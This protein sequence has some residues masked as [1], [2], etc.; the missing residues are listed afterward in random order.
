[1]AIAEASEASEASGNAEAVSGSRR[2]GTALAE[3]LARP[4]ATET[5]HDRYGAVAGVP[6]AA[7]GRAGSGRGRLPGA[8]GP[9]RGRAPAGGIVAL[10]AQL[11]AQMSIRALF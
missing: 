4:T 10:G 2:S 3:R 8:G 9:G 5:A 6:L 11:S 1:M 7:A